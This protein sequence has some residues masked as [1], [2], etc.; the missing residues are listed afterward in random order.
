[1]KHRLFFALALLCALAP[2]GGIAE[3]CDLCAIYSAT[4][5]SGL[6][7]RGFGAGVAEQFTHFGT[8]KDDSKTQPNPFGQFLDSSIT[9]IFGSYDFNKY[10]G[11]QLTLP[12]IVRSFRRVEGGAVETG[13]VAGLGDMSLVGRF[14]PYQKF[15]ERFSLSW[16]LLGGV[17]FPTGSTSRLKEELNED[18]DPADPNER[19]GVHGH[20]LTLGSGSFDGVVGTKIYTRWRRFL[21]TSD[22]QYAI[23]SRGT[24]DYR[25]ANDLH[26]NLGLGGYVFL[27]HNFTLAA[28][29]RVSGEHKGLD[30][31][32]GMPVDDT[33][34]TTV[35][36]GPDFLFT[37][38]EHLSANLGADIPVL[39]HNTAFQSVPDYRI[40][41]AASWRF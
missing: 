5:A 11:L 34:L 23:R 32:A 28:L 31:L 12:V 18:M 29:A 2:W 35:S 13:T 33:G 17:K 7:G 41:A 24:I 14:Q 20:D 1:M 39:I 10:A 4:N 8:L 30:D 38:T 9:Q 19:S 37:W 36:L 22:I 6:D 3:A 26:W 15:T 16:H 27:R 40:R 25:F 21:A